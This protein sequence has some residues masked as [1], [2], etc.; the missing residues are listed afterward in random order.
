VTLI[1][2]LKHHRTRTGRGNDCVRVL[3]IKYGPGEKSAL[4][5]HPDAVAIM[6][7]EGTVN[8]HLPGGK[9]EPGQPMVPGSAAWTPATV[10]LPENVG[11]KAMEVL[12]VEMKHGATMHHEED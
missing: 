11:T 4:H 9:M 5:E 10:H 3:R 12:F 7:T 8:V 6:L 1:V 2:E